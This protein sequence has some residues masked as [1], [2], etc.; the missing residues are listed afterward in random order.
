MD[1]LSILQGVCNVGFLPV[2]DITPHIHYI[3]N[4]A[5]LDAL[6]YFDNQF[7]ALEDKVI[8]RLAPK[9][10]YAG[11][12]KIPD[13]AQRRP[14]SGKVTSVGCKCKY[15]NEGDTVVYNRYSGTTIHGNIYGIDHPMLQN[16]DYV[17][18]H[19]KDVV[20]KIERR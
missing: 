2:G 9:K 4:K 15:V 3:K 14:F 19:E 13:K 17:V 8:I 16:V 10:A 1:I 6:Y 18:V 20:A 11:N 5:R 7:H 12:V